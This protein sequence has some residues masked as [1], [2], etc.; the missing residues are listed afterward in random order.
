VRKVIVQELALHSAAQ[1][2]RPKKLAERRRV[3]G[4]SAVLAQFA[5]QTAERII[6]ESRDTLRHIVVVA[7]AAALIEGV[8]P[9]AIVQIHPECLARQPPQIGHH[10]RGNVFDA[11]L[12]Q[13]QRQVMV[14]DDIVFPLRAPDDRD[15]ML[16]EEV[17]FLAIRMIAPALAFSLDLTHADGDLGRAQGCDRYRMYTGFPGKRHCSLLRGR[18]CAPQN[19]VRY[20]LTATKEKPCHAALP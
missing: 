13:R 19:A 18:S 10:R 16:A 3:L 20:S 15:Q 8:Q 1:K 17:G 11:F 2:V 4:K 7:P 9:A 12:V 5:G 6:L 14:V